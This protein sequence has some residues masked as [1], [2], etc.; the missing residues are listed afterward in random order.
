MSGKKH[1]GN[2]RKNNRAKNSYQRN[3]NRKS[4]NH[5]SGQR[6]DGQRKAGGSSGDDDL[7]FFDLE[8]DEDK[9]KE[10]SWLDDPEWSEESEEEWEEEPEEE[11][12]QDDP[13]A[14]DELDDIDEPGDLEDL[15]IPEDGISKQ[16]ITKR[17]ISEGNKNFEEKGPEES[18]AVKAS[19]EP[20]IPEEMKWPKEP[21]VPDW[22]EEPK[23]VKPAQEQAWPEPSGWPEGGESMEAAQAPEYEER[24]DMEEAEEDDW[25]EEDN[26]TKED[27]W[28]R[29]DSRSYYFE[30]T[31]RQRTK[32]NRRRN[33]AAGRPGVR[34]TAEGGKKRGRRRPKKIVRL[35]FSLVK[36]LIM[37]ALVLFVAR[38][39]SAGYCVKPEITVE[40]GDNCPKVEQ[41]LKWKNKNAKFVSDINEETVL[42]HPGDYGVV[43]EVYGKKS[44][45][46]IHVKDT[47]APEVVTKEVT[48]NINGSVEP[49]AFIE[50]I[51]DKSD[52]SVRF[53]E[54]PDFAKEG[55]Q[56]VLLEVE[57][58]SGNITE[59]NASLNVISDSVPPK[60]SGVKE[61]TMTIGSSISYKKGVKAVDDRDGEVEVQVDTSAVDTKKVGNYEVVYRAVDSAGNEAVAKTTLH[62]KRAT[63]ETVTEE[64]INGEA[65]AVLASILTDSMS[66]YDKAKAIYWWCHDKIAY[67]DNAPKSD[68][69]HGAY[70]GIVE[71]KGD[72][73]TYA[74]TAKCLLT[75]AKIKNMDIERI[76]SG[77][78]MHYW[79]IIDI[80]E[81][82]HHFDTCRR[83]DGSTFF[84]KND[85]EIKKYSDGHNGTHNYDR[86]KYPE[87]P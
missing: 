50:E 4:Y 49:D 60:I 8:E 87:I 63:S 33:N 39:F 23:K 45:S 44:A 83:A 66:E 6:T 5:Y 10:E 51:T 76:P 55:N 18:E 41:F 77:N 22:L 68:W 42:E 52:V 71:R 67:S 14:I 38:L 48:V 79:N 20:E 74:A 15:D 31:E 28:F 73:Y 61:L 24:S 64:M 9:D 12:W 54:A 35:I 21:E 53:K 25:P 3:N 58:E 85:A 75:R 65:D 78:L 57:D 47:T 7:D 40:A 36:L 11:E 69:V 26:R 84:Y 13:D 19:K 34:G 72:C 29:R 46:V 27:D 62:V 1:P 70:Q 2:K 43:I 30:D 17:D 32:R 86:S 82:W 81:G 80:G 37:L 59:A 56:T 16:D